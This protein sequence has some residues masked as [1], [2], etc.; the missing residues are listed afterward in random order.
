MADEHAFNVKVL[1][2][3]GE[4]FDGEVEQVSTRTAVGEIGI[5]AN[6]APLV[7]RLRPTELRLHVSDGDVKRFAQAEGW[8]EVFGNHALVLVG[9]AVEPGDLDS[10]DLKEQISSAEKRLSEAEE[11]SAAEKTA[12]LEKDRYEAFLSVAEQA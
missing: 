3:E 8:L 9:E 12:A 6:H 10:A 5:R 11:G 2:P 4:V 1:T 7:A